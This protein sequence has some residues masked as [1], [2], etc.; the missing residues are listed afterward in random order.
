[1]DVAFA[2]PIKLIANALGP[3]PASMSERARRAGVPVAALVGAREHAVRQLN[4]G[5]DMIVAQGSEAGGHTGTVST[6]VLVPGSA[7]GR[8]RIGSPCWPP[9]ASSPAPRWRP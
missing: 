2:H 8:R 7:R 9:V 5:V 4:A 6:L 1:M 3:P